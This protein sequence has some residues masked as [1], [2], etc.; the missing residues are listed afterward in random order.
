MSLFRNL[1]RT[2]E[3]F[4]ASDNNATKITSE[5]VDSLSVYFEAPVNLIQINDQDMIIE[6]DILGEF[7]ANVRGANQS[8]LARGLLLRFK[9]D[10]QVY[11]LVRNPKPQ[12]MFNRTKIYCKLT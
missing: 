8:K 7:R 6:G 5:D 2:A 3:F 12:R 4:K 11:R 10:L 9:G 1:E